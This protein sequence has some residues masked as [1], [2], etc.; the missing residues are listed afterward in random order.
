MLR[1]STH[2]CPAT[3]DWTDLFMFLGDRAAKV[4]GKE[5]ARF[6]VPEQGEVLYSG[7]S[8]MAA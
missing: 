1:Y 4:S 2:L 5:A 7:S 6:P 8:G 3:S